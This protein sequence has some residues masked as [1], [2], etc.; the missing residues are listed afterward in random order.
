MPRK[1]P[2]I[3]LSDALERASAGLACL[4]ISAAEARVQEGAGGSA[5]AKL[6]PEA[7]RQFKAVKSA[8]L[9]F[10]RVVKSGKG[11]SAN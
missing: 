10:E 1:R 6:P 3:N 5:A 2:A 8:L 7:A 4:E 9:D 11:R